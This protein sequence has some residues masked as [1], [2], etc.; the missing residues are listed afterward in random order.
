MVQEVESL[1]QLIKIIN[2]AGSKA[3]IIDF[4][5]TW[6][7]PC[8]TIS[9]KV[10]ELG[11]QNPTIIV[12]KVDVDKVPDVAEKY[13]IS[14]MPTFKVIKDGQVVDTMVGGDPERLVALFDKH[15]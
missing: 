9:P 3:I 8:K 14:A 13:D 12:L 5:A 10:A 15:K 1:D 6:C 7:G 2:E 4:F 11:G